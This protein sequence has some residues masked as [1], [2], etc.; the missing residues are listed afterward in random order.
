MQAD[1]IGQLIT[2]LGLS[3]IFLFM[4]YK[5]WQRHMQMTDTIIGILREELKI[6]QERRAGETVVS[7]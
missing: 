2:Q 4:L 1:Q 5:L 7:D 6:A 3:A